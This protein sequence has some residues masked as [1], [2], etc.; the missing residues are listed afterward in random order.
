MS[1]LEDLERLQAQLSGYVQENPEYGAGRRHLLFV[2]GTMKTGLRNHGRLA[3]ARCLGQA[4]TRGECFLMWTKR[5]P[6]TKLLAPVVQPDGTFRIRG[7]LYEVDGPTLSEIDLC[8]GHPVV[9]ERLQVD[10]DLDA[11]YRG[12]NQ[13]LYGAWM[14]YWGA[15]PEQKLTRA[16]VKLT[17]DIMEFCP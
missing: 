1:Y 8:E 13:N 14:Y 5:V 15:T 2:Y 7:E 10:I 16:G 17:G 12:V 4:V 11:P 9:Y 3:K 6:G